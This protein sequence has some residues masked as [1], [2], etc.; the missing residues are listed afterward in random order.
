M[1]E[2]ELE[3]FPVIPKDFVGK[4]TMMREQMGKLLQ[5]LNETVAKI[6]AGMSTPESELL[7]GTTHDLGVIAPEA[8]EAFM[9]VHEAHMGVMKMGNEFADSLPGKIAEIDARM[10]RELAPYAAANF[11]PKAQEPV[12]LFKDLIDFR[13]YKYYMTFTVETLNGGL[14]LPESDLPRMR[15]KVSGNIWENWNSQLV[16]EKNKKPEARHL[17]TRTQPQAHSQPVE[18][19]N[20]EPE[21]TANFQSAYVFDLKVLTRLGLV[22][23]APVLPKP[24]KP[25][26]NIWENW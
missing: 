9:D 12:P 16:E 15:Q 18:E 13:W 11:I 5:I 1:M 2:P 25:L 21:D 4:V 20:K 26:G 23:Q 7:K 3:G 24:Q 6:P 22:P 14:P 8:F 19:K 17:P 10:A